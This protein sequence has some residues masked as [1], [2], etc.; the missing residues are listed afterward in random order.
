[1]IEGESLIEF[2]C[3]FPIKVMGRDNTGFK[4]HVLQL[5]SPHVDDITTAEVATR[6]SKNGN[7]ISLTV[8]IDA[9][10]QAQLDRIYQALT[11]SEQ[12]LYVL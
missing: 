2:P 7:F 3:R 9:R 11:A 5:I 6:A 8:M 12:V 10:N 1:M 4:A